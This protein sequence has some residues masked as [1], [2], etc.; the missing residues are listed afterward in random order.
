M[1]ISVK[2]TFSPRKDAVGADVI[3]GVAGKDTKCALQHN[4]E[5]ATS[6]C[7]AFSGRMDHCSK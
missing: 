7:L 5:N 3:I 4:S 1:H 2:E 6:S